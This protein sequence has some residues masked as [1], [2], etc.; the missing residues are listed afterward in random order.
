MTPNDFGHNLPRR[1]PHP[2]YSLGICP[3]DFYLFEKV[4]S[5]MVR[6][7]VLDEIDFLEE[8]TQFLTGFQ[9]L[10]YNASFEVGSN[11]MKK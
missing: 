3:S 5:G 6:P 4:K 2:L 10:D 9:G 1:L 11:A 8:V 7:E